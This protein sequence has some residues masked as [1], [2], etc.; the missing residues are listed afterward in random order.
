MIS[1]GSCG[2]CFYWN[3]NV[4]QL[5]SKL[6]IE[7]LQTQRKSPSKV[8]FRLPFF[9]PKS[10]FIATYGAALLR[11]VCGIFPVHFWWKIAFWQRKTAVQENFFRTN[12]SHWKVPSNGIKNMRVTVDIPHR[13]A[14][15][16]FSCFNRSISYN[17]LHKGVII[18][19][20][21]LSRNS[22]DKFRCKRKYC[23]VSCYVG[24]M[25]SQVHV[26]PKIRCKFVS[27]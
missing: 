1:W 5:M 7:Y 20:A 6:H 16:K 11:F 12:F 4:I 10:S 19:K 15:R 27:F 21:T 2:K 22:R 9:T 18:E 14:K 3:K 24:I 25:T 17:P 26:L 13:I 23:H 8:M